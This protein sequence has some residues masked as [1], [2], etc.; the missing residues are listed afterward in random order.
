MEE[1]E[2]MED[3]EIVDLYWR[4]KEC[5]VWETEKKYGKY[6]FSVAWNILFCK[7]DS[8]ECVNDTY[9]AAWNSIPPKRP[10]V[11]S[12]FLGKITRNKAID[13][14]RKKSAGKRAVFHMVDIYGETEKLETAFV[15]SLEQKQ[16]EKELAEMLN[17]FLHSLRKADRDIFIRRYWYLD[18]IKAVAQRHKYTESRVKS[19]LFRS[20][21]KLLKL[22]EKRGGK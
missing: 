10:A 22:L 15:Y 20:R 9:L 2:I 5:A 19:S 7:E 13:C 21:K 1:R 14:F 3:R 17:Y 18:S 11:L 12:A 6:C 8:E 16:D 4:R